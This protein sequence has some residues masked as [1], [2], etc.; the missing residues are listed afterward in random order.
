MDQPKLARL[1]HL[2]TLMA[3]NVNYSVRELAS[4][5]HTSYRSIYRYIDTLRDCGFLVE[6]VH[7][8]IYK[9]VKSPRQYPDFRKLAYFTEEEA[10]IIGSLIDELDDTNNLKAGLKRKL[11]SIYDVTN[12]KKFTNKKGTAVII[13]NLNKAI[14]EKR[15]VVL[16]AYQSG[17]GTERD[18]IVE[19]FALTFNH[20]DI[21]AYDLEDGVNKVFKISRIR[22]VE[23]LDEDWTETKSHKRGYTDCFRMSGYRK[24]HVKLK[25]GNL[26]KNLLVEEY[27][28][29]EKHI[30]RYGDKWIFEDDVTCM[31][32]IGRF[33]IGLAD[34][35]QI[36]KGEELKE[37]VGKFTEENLQHYTNAIV[38]Y[39]NSNSI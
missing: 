37:Y 36:L 23:V 33:V 18:R 5:M 35:I 13:A 14:T 9:L 26:S 38:R 21:W 19:P 17:S 8:S 6:K 1:L 24:F 29:S 12:I 11:V 15:K 27:P 31:Q 2:M 30:R 4:A 7:G 20:I 34:D 10:Q 22:E 16:K 32:G 3:G 25:M 39:G 28:M